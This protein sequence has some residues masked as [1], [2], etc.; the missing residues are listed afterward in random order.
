MK[1]RLRSTAAQAGRPG[2]TASAQPQSAPEAPAEKRTNPFTDADLERAW[3][4]VADIVSGQQGLASTLS[5]VK[6]VVDGTKVILHFPGKVILDMTQP[7]LPA[8]QRHMADVLSN[9][10]FELVC[11][12]DMSQLPPELG[13][14]EKLYNEMLNEHPALREFIA[15]FGMRRI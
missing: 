4:G 9:D 5:I 13:P 15:E 1:E 6:P 12:D 8:I 7:F 2:T 11:D 3:A 10:V 14:D